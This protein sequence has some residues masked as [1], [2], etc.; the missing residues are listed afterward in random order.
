M[1]GKIMFKLRC[2]FGNGLIL[3][4]NMVMD[5]QQFHFIATNAMKRQVETAML[6]PGERAVQ[7]PYGDRKPDDM[8]PKKKNRIVKWLVGFLK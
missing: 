8:K 5:S 6:R 4:D 3:T 2:G 7:P 1:E